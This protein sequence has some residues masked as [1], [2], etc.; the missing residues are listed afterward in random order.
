MRTID[1]KDQRLVNGSREGK[2]GL[3]ETVEIVLL[4]LQGHQTSERKSVY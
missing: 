4:S 1:R 3:S 2:S